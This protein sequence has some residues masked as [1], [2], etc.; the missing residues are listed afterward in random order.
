MIKRI[1]DSDHFICKVISQTGKITEERSFDNLEQAKKFK[2]TKKSL[3][4]VKNVEIYTSPTNA[5]P[6]Q[7]DEEHMVCCICN[8]PIDSA[9]GNNADPICEGECCEAC[10]EKYVIPARMLKMNKPFKSELFV[11]CKECGMP[12]ILESGENE[13]ECGA[14]YNRF[15]QQFADREEW[16]EEDRYGTDGPQNQTDD[17]FEE[18]TKAVRKTNRPLKHKKL[19]IST[20]TAQKIAQATTT[21][22][23]RAY[24]GEYIDEFYERYLGVNVYKNDKG[25]YTAQFLEQKLSGETPEEIEE[26]IA[27]A[28]SDYVKA[29]TNDF[30]IKEVKEIKKDLTKGGDKK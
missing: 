6:I 29:Y 9:Y 18:I 23:S 5:L 4:E 30:E 12:V 11:K 27:K 17:S 16:D 28:S 26:K 2:E 13:C 22:D 1:K 19:K 20:E 21:L 3:P 25:I 15:G 24:I 10:N 14:C 8:K 7:D